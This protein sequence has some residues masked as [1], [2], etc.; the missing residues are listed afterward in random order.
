M[1]P[2]Y[3]VSQSG[4]SPVSASSNMS[5]PLFGNLTKMFQPILV[6]RASKDSGK[7]VAKKIK[8][9][10]TSGGKWPQTVLFPEGLTTNG[11]ALTY[12]KLGAFTPNVP[13][14]PVLC[15]YNNKLTDLGWVDGGPG[16]GELAFKCL[17]SPWI[18]MSVEYLPPY[19]PNE[20]EK[21]D[22]HLFARNV[23]QVMADKL[24]VS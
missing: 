21:E 13:V 19:V 3:L 9:R 24:Q 12:F 15:R 8:D 6:D 5:I 22:T 1:D 2:I 7:D 18:N 20:A 10:A 17:C 4:A 23:R 16:V 11:Q 14:Q